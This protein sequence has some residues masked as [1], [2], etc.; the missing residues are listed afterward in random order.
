VRVRLVQ[1]I[2]LALLL[3][4]LGSAEARRHTTGL[5][6]DRVARGVGA[7]APEA[8][9]SAFRPRT[10]K[11]R[12]DLRPF[13]P[14]VLKLTRATAPGLLFLT[15]RATDEGR[16]SGPM[17]IDDRGQLVWFHPVRNRFSSNLQVVRY[18]GRRALAWWEGKFV[19]GYGYGSFVVADETYRRVARIQARNGYRA[20]FH[21]VEF[22]PR[23]T[24]VMLIYSAVNRDLTPY[25]G[26]ANAQV[27][28]NIVQEVDLGTGKVLLQ[29]H[30]LAAAGP[31]E[32]YRPAPTDNSQGYDYFHANSI[33]VDGDG[34]LLISS[35]NT[36]AVYKIDRRTG[37]LIWQ[38]GGKRS[39]FKMGQ[40]ARF[41]WQHDVRHLGNGRVSIFDNGAAP[42]VHDRSRGLI[43]KLDTGKMEA[44]VIREYP[45]P[46]DLLASSQG[47]F[48]P[49]SGDR[50]L[51]G[52]GSER[53]LSEYDRKGRVL[54]TMQFPKN[55]N[56]YRALRYGW[57]GRPAER[58]AIA[59][60][61]RRGRVIVYAS[62]NGA[63]NVA[64]W[65]VLA[66]RKPKRL[67]HVR[68]RRWKRFETAVRVL[69]AR[70]LRYF[71]VQAIGRRGR[72]LRTSRTTRP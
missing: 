10:F 24:V 67:H 16:Q 17:I 57:R 38:L 23:G 28:D 18:R 25:G 62:W 3:T 33:D 61:R 55:V 11:T 69:H 6:G 4:P 35:R 72:I 2:A 45:P 13:K 20:D 22:T 58:P 39:S 36:H 34:N 5:G 12:P 70:K 51:L 50:F 31:G 65:R 64:R 52:W 49:L 32:S 14:S 21:D 63:T 8:A 15:A 29:W 46:V 43:L 47:S 42:K 37:A 66:G 71:A 48:Q 40:G 53:Y 9:V 41:A 26:P 19:L 7:L 1:G 30:S 68:S 27:L 44:S 60:R 59:A 54:L 56:S